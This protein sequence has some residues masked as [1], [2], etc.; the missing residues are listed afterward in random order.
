LISEVGDGNNTLFWTNKWING[1]RISDLAPR[2]LHAIL[3]AVVSKR[4][5]QEALSNRNWISDIK[6]AITVG[7]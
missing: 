6:G 5:V 2:L 1:R 3:K 4:T 7:A